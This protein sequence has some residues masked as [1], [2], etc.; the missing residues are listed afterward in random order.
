MRLKCFS[1]YVNIV[2]SSLCIYVLLHALPSLYQKGKKPW[3]RGCKVNRQNPFSTLRVH[4]FQSTRCLF[5]FT[6]DEMGNRMFQ[7]IV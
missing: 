2:N 7:S 6:V 4:L 5:F 1:D 3:E